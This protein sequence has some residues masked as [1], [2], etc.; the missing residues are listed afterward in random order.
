MSLH[1]RDLFPSDVHS[2][3]ALLSHV[4]VVF[5]V[6]RTLHAVFTMAADVHPSQQCT[7]VLTNTSH[8]FTH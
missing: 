8:L 7:N 5:N 4:A 6:L 3:V 1:N 2:E